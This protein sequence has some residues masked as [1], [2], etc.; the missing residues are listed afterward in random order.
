M[1]ACVC[2]WLFDNWWWRI[3]L[4]LIFILPIAYYS[5][6]ASSVC[7]SVCA[8]CTDNMMQDSACCNQWWRWKLY[9]LFCIVKMNEN[10]MMWSVLLVSGYEHS[11]KSFKSHARWNNA[12]RRMMR[13]A[14]F[15]WKEIFLGCQGFIQVVTGPN[16]SYILLQRIKGIY[17][18][19]RES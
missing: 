16:R 17:S 5:G 7:L 18:K 8:T 15:R 14:W 9:T 6:G 13:K 4:S 2:V 1:H 19:T 10:V 12:R 3:S 11:K